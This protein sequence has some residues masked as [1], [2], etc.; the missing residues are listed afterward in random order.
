[1]SNTTIRQLAY[2][3]SAGPG[4]IT[5]LKGK[6]VLIG[7]PDKWEFPLEQ[8]EN[9]LLKAI[10]S[11]DDIKLIKPPTESD[12]ASKSEMN[13]YISAIHFPLLRVCNEC[14]SLF[15]YTQYEFSLS[16]D[17]YTVS[18]F[19]KEVNSKI[20]DYNSLLI[21][22]NKKEYS[23]KKINHIDKLFCPNC[24]KL[25]HILPDRIYSQTNPSFSRMTEILHEGLVSTIPFRFVAVCNKGHIFDLPIKKLICKPNCSNYI[26]NIDFSKNEV[27]CSICKRP[28]SLDT[29]KEET[30][31]MKYHSTYFYWMDIFYPL[32]STDEDTDSVCEGEIQVSMRGD[33]KIW[34]PI[35]RSALKIFKHN[36]SPRKRE[37]LSEELRTELDK[38]QKK[39]ENNADINNTLKNYELNPKWIQE[40]ADLDENIIK[41]NIKSMLART[42]KAPEDWKITEVDVRKVEYQYLKSN[43]SLD[44]N[45]LSFRHEDIEKS[46]LMDTL[47]NLIVIDKAIINQTLIGFNRIRSE[48]FES[49]EDGEE[50]KS[51]FVP[52]TAKNLYPTVETKTEG[53]FIELKRDKLNEWVNKNSLYIQSIHNKI[54][55][56]PVS[57]MV[58]FSK[59]KKKR[60][61]ELAEFFL[62]HSL[63]HYLIQSLCFSSGY[64]A[65]SLRERLYFFDNVRGLAILTSSGD[66]EG[67]LGGVAYNGS[68]T[69]IIKHFK[70]M[71]E[72]LEICSNDPI[73]QMSEPHGHQNHNFAACHACIILPETACE[74]MNQYLDRNSLI[75]SL[76][77]NIPQGFFRKE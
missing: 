1:M 74:F 64:N 21:K 15:D 33:R 26:F 41:L 60:D 42:E 68:L 24:S 50:K 29:I 39:L 40:F 69:R 54:K 70:S 71:L 13:K 3:L 52:V 51:I 53:F 43:K 18:T 72:N 55:T 32:N 47:S 28:K 67:S 59:D 44:T 22:N 37:E 9:I 34:Y 2:I 58:L 36:I 65:M 27:S 49:I 31:G 73:C 48:S 6:S 35:N 23:K 11:G 25:K 45:Y 46:S 38:L 4:S 5:E 8:Y 20:N 63:S 61:I 19:L 14:N 10:I 30:K 66:S 12:I 16:D 17:V 76:E 57:S 75:G 7:G 77:E 56:I 62:L